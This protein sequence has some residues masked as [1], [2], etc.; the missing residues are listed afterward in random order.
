MSVNSYNIHI[1]MIMFH[2]KHRN[3]ISFLDILIIILYIN[4]DTT[5]MVES[6]QGR[7]SAA[8]TFN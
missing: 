7:K 1:K 6:G 2:V 8:L 4:I 3:I 5:L